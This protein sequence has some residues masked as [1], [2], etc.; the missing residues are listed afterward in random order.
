MRGAIPDSISKSITGA[1]TAV[2]LLVILVILVS[3]S[4][5]AIHRR[6]AAKRKMTLARENPYSMEVDGYYVEMKNIS[7]ITSSIPAASNEC[8]ATNAIMAVNP[9]YSCHSDPD[10]APDHAPRE[11][12]T[13]KEHD[14]A[15]ID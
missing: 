11:M 4:A 12:V 2:A 9:A 14:Y 6:K 7:A 5:I 8:Y 13:S 15:V 10:V 1:C 3:V